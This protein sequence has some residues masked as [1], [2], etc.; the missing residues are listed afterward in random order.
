MLYCSF[1]IG[2]NK[3]KTYRFRPNNKNNFR[4]FE[5][6]REQDM[7]KRKS[8]GHPSGKKSNGGLAF[9]NVRQSAGADKTELDSPM[10]DLPEGPAITSFRQLEADIRNLQCKRQSPEIEPRTREN[11]IAQLLSALDMRDATILSLEAEVENARADKDLIEIL[12]D[13]LALA[14][15]ELKRLHAE[16]FDNQVTRIRATECIE[17]FTAQNT[18]LC[19]KVQDFETYIDA[20]ENEGS[21]GPDTVDVFDLSSDPIIDIGIGRAPVERSNAFCNVEILPMPAKQV[22]VAIGPAANDNRQY[23]L[24]KAET[25]IGRSRSS[26][27]RIV[28]KYTSREHARIIQ[29]DAQTIIEDLGSTN[30]FLINSKA[31]KRHRLQHGDRLKI[32]TEEFEFLDL[33]H[34][35]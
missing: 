10:E 20:M 17:K 1:D 31:V 32:G 29:D 4:S 15:E 21:G 7:A 2:Y 18:E 13:D 11:R 24:S 14:N 30:G 27:I 6:D 19:A 3:N 35:H 5:C 33:S 9:L 22:L 12:K 34:S 25:T 28:S 26:D 16:A 23:S 8:G